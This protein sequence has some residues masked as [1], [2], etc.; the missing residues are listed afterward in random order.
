MELPK[1]L[2]EK[3]YKLISSAK[4]DGKI[5]RGANETTKSAER[6]EAKLVVSAADVTPPEVIAHLPLISKEKSIPFAQVPAKSELGAAAGLPVGTAAVAVVG[7]GEERKLLDDITKSLKVLAGPAKPSEPPA[8]S[9][10]Q[11]KQV[12]L[13]PE[14]S[15]SRASSDQKKVAE[16]KPAEAPKEEKKPAEKPAPKPEAKPAEKKAEAPAEAKPK[17]EPEEKKEEV[18]EKAKPEEEPKAEEK[19]KEE[20]GEEPTKE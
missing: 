11:E 15:S 7:A 5:R 12:P 13:R 6:G 18:E 2:T 10:T 16:A 8:G 9:D 17:E 1:E 4:A 20:K 3:I 19:E 14:D